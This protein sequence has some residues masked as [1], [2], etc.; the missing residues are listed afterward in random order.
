MF[1]A[2]I[3]SFGLPPGFAGVSLGGAEYPKLFRT[4]LASISKTSPIRTGL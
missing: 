4:D 1:I 3:G 2:V